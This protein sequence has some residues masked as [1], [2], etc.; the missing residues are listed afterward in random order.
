MALA[1]FHIQKGSSGSGGGL[2]NHID[3][4]EGFEHSFKSADP[5]KRKLNH[6]FIAN[7][8]CKL[9]LEKAVQKRIEDA[10]KGPR[11]VRKDAV[12]HINLILTG[13]HERMHEIF[14]DKELAKDWIRA[15]S[16]FVAENYG[17]DNI[18][19]FVLHMDEKTPHIHCVV[20]PITDKG[21]LSAKEVMGNRVNLQQM[22]NKYADAMKPFGLE[23][24]RTNPEIKH[25][26]TKEFYKDMREEL[27]ARW[28]ETL[29]HKGEIKML[30]KEEKHLQATIGSLKT[31]DAI[32]NI[33]Q[34]KKKLKDTEGELKETLKRLADSERE[35]KRLLQDKLDNNTVIQRLKNEVNK[36]KKALNDK[37][38]DINDIKTKTANTV[39]E[40]VNNALVNNKLDA[41][42]D[43]YD[44]RIHIRHKDE[45]PKH[46]KGKSV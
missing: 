44:G 29:K 11:K 7:D 6:E 33:L 46:D 34:P 4:T 25:Q 5:D 15:N 45:K 12:K 10:Y 43:V 3:R 37:S 24:G 26:D 9:P 1:V 13:S 32:V 20:V 36:F 27:N 23:R 16:K 28:Q 31:K 17:K 14:K 30:E 35:N 39:I 41:R 21:G 2:G 19:R 38:K 18:V 40:I 8:Y 22:Q 42:F